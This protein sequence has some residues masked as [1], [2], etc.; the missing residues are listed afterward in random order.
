MGLLDFILNL[1]GLLLWLNW[2]AVGLT[3][4]S[5]PFGPSLI[6]T[7]KRTETVTPQRWLSLAVLLAILSLRP[8]FYFQIGPSVGWMP[9]QSLGAISLVF[10]SDYFGRMFLF[11]LVEFGLWLASFYSC[12][13]LISAANQQLSDTDFCQRLVR[14]QLGFVER[15]PAVVK[16]LLPWFGA[17][18]A[19]VF[20][21][22]SLAR[23]G[24][25][26]EPKSSTHLWQQ[27]VVIGLASFLTWKWLL[28]TIF[29]L[30]L[31]N[32]YVYLGNSVWWNFIS[33][34]AGHLSF[35]IS[36]LPLQ[37]GKFDLVP[38]IMIAATLALAEFL[39][40]SLPQL[41]LQLP[42]YF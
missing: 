25:L 41:Y 1:V 20:A 23:M 19:W 27:A 24:M 30:A 22:P 16:L 37:I 26:P 3:N 15:L 14:L 2:R 35:P 17:T 31:L 21:A 8:F 28:V 10:R 11:S 18:L 13:L 39:Q 34:T 42:L 38:F 4:R 32:S 29:A 33:H 40:R 12:L 7:L 9:S 6:S 5:N 36:W